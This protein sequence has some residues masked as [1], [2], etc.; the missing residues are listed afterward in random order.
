MTH[1]AY[2]KGA[3]KDPYKARSWFDRFDCDVVRFGCDIASILRAQS[4]CWI[5]PLV[6]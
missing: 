5:G 1:K 2:N 4:Q 6:M 3:P